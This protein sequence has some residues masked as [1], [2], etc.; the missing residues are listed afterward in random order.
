MLLEVKDLKISVNGTTL[1][2]NV[3]MSVREGEIVAIIGPN[4]AGKSTFLKALLNLVPYSGEVKWK[5]GVKI[6]YLPQDLSKESFTLFPI[7][8]RDFF[9]LKGVSDDE[10][11]ATLERMGVAEV[12][13][14]RMS[15]LSAGQFQR[16]LIGWS[17]VDKPDVLL[18]DEPT[19][20]ID[21][22]GAKVFYEL[23]YEIAKKRGVSVLFVTHELSA[24]YSFVDNVL[25]L[26]KSCLA[27]GPP[28]KVLTQQTLEETYGASLKFH[29]HEGD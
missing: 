18:L 20:G 10:A 21:I 8:V 26:H 23:V 5:A 7:T 1:L 22:G 16:V 2:S 9:A 17:F 28:K 6:N 14:K 25:C 3:S 13:D 19:T 15:T 24:I 27:Y 29:V 12:M 11:R 4:G